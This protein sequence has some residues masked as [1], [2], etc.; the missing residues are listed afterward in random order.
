[1]SETTEFLITV[2]CCLILTPVVGG[3]IGLLCSLLDWLEVKAC[4]FI[5]GISK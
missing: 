4:G 2:V 3:V 1:M 5:K